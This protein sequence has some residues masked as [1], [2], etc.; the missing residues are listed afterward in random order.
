MDIMGDYVESTVRTDRLFCSNCR[1]ALKKGEEAVFEIY[2]NSL[3]KREMLNC[4]CSECGGYY[5]DELI[6]SSTHPYDLDF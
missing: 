6:A 4:Y 5:E 3:G 2:W 1:R